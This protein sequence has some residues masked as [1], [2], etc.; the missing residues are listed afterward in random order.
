M[1]EKFSRSWE[2][3]KAS[4]NVLKQDRE[5]LVFPLL[6]LISSILVIASFAIPLFASGTAQRL[7]EGAD[8]ENYHLVVMFLFYLV[9]YFIIFFFNTALIGAAL[10][11]LEGGDPTVKD[12]LR[13]ASER[14]VSIF[15][16]AV[17]AATVGL[18]LRVIEERAGWIGRW[19]AGLLG[20]AFTVV[21]FMVVPI[22]VTRNV[23]PIEAIKESATLL[24]RT[25]GENIIGN[26]GIGL[27]FIAVHIAL[28]VVGGF[29]AFTALKSGMGSLAVL[30]VGAMI[31]AFIVAALVQTAL[32]G[33]YSAALFRYATN[34]GQVGAGF[35]ATLLGDA[36]KHR[37]R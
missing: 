31:I 5:M 21:T 23:G 30:V 35:D 32:Q 14:V 33:V 25:W 10:I 12:G 7:S 9:Q 16:Y 11:R 24:K 29:L 2:L 6:S 8:A 15:G 37:A 13:I 34:D 27:I 28:F 26:A 17:I 36:F 4:A 19:I 22:L 18:I 20:A 3:V 1:I